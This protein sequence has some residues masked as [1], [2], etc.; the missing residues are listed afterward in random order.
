MIFSSRI[1]VSMSS[2]HDPIAVVR[3]PTWTF[4][5]FKN[6]PVV[7]AYRLNPQSCERLVF[8]PA[9][10]LASSRSGI[11]C[12]CWAL[13]SHQSSFLFLLLAWCFFFLLILLLRG[14]PLSL[15]C[16]RGLIALND[17]NRLSQTWGEIEFPFIC[18][19]SLQYILVRYGGPVVLQI[20][21]IMSN[22]IILQL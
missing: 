1:V 4:S 11:S 6:S 19:T 20:S 12:L 3:L 8:S 10:L 22:R 13:V 5:S 14:T 15:C 7:T 16:I 9:F 21:K 2:A 17:L 18:M